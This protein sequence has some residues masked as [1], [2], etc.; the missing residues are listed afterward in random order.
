MIFQVQVQTLK[1]PT[2]HQLVSHSYP[3]HILAVAHFVHAAAVSAVAGCSGPCSP[4]LAVAGSR[5]AAVRGADP[6]LGRRPVAAPRPASVAQIRGSDVH[7]AGLHGP[8]HGR[9]VLNN[10]R[11]IR[12]AREA[13]ADLCQARFEGSARR[14]SEDGQSVAA[15]AEA[16]VE[17][18]ARC[19]VAVLTTCSLNPVVA[20]L[21]LSAM[22]VAPAGAQ[23]KSN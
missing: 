16:A 7:G 13:V 12:L 17:R 18:P 19:C 14:T 20:G 1:N 21:V 11:V 23:K 15:V 2:L 4:F 10:Q 3:V 8:C 9:L 5:G 6:A 22:G